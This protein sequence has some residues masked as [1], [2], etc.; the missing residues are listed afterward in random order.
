MMMAAVVGQVKDAATTTGTT[1]EA[2]I[3]QFA[4]FER[5][6]AKGNDKKRK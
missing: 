1:V 5:L 2:P 3:T 6:E 4:N